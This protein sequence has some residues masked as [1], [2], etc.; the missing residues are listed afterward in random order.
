MKEYDS[1]PQSE[2]IIKEDG[3]IYHLNLKPEEIADT[4]ILVGDP[5]RVQMIS[6]FFEEI[7]IRQSNREIVTHTGI[8][9]NKKLT[10]MSTGMGTDNID[11]V[12]NELDALV[13]IDLISR[14]IKEKKK[15]LQLVRLGTSGAIHQDIPVNSFIVSDYGLGMDSLANFY[16]ISFNVQEEKLTNA[17]IKQTEWPEKFG[18]PYIKGS[19]KE[20]K[21]LFCDD[22]FIHGITAT[23]PGF[24]GPQGRKL[25]LNPHIS[26]LVDR[27]HAFQ[28]EGQR[29][30]NIEM[31]TSALY[32]LGHSLGHQTL[33]ICVAIANRNIK[34]INRDYHQAI[35]ELVRI[36]LQ[37]LTP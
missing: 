12:V 26:D 8:Y 32:S 30:T 15:S 35:E 21:S 3:R 14:R 25:R 9:N 27:L 36:V 2:L 18:K 20:L 31:E 16:D 37:R 13:N 29:I 6:S 17:F 1:I 33:T 22:R 24:Y 28:Y 34:A 10:V 5:G 23:A 11:I 19:S 7:I 4:V